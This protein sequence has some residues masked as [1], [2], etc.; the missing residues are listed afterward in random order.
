M[1]INFTKINLLTFNVG[2]IFL[3]VAI[4]QSHYYCFFNFAILVSTQPMDEST[5]AISYGFK[6]MVQAIFVDST[7]HKENISNAVSYFK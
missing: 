4:M 7:I 5:L 6:L 3:T 2:L 1:G